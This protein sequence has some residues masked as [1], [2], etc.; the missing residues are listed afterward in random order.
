MADK[1]TAD[2]A[3]DTDIDA[4]DPI[5]SS[6][7]ATDTA[8]AIAPA[9]AAATA[10]D[11][12]AA[13]TTDT[14]AADTTAAPTAD[15]TATDTAAVTASANA[16]ATATD[17]AAVIAPATTAAAAPATPVPKA[18]KKERSPVHGYYDLPVLSLEEATEKLIKVIPDI[19][20]Y[21]ATAKKDCNKEST[22]LTVDESAA[23]YL[24]TMASP[25]VWYLNDAFQTEKRR[26]LKPWLSYLKLFVNAIEKLPSTTKTLWRSL[27]TDNPLIFYEGAA[28]TW[29]N[30]TSC[31]LNVKMTQ[32]YLNRQIATVFA[33]NAIN[34]KD[35]SKFSAYPD[36]QEVVLI[37]GTRLSVVGGP[38]H[39]RDHFT[40]VHMQEEEN[41][42][43]TQTVNK[44]G[45]STK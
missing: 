40:I 45:E 8:V 4:S 15:T 34:A 30:I 39:F 17:S 20:A 23:I 28:Y 42:S 16:A 10:T 33:I 44:D 6:A 13:P 5:T 26:V 19:A 21:V 9:N 37:P 32:Y 24:Y 14:T 43:P 38:L 2:P 31:S 41:S 25:V 29:W 27:A 12:T 1:P 18:E 11:T 35:I 22:L 3:A 36:E 7:T